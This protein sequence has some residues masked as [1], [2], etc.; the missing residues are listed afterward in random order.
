MLEAEAMEHEPVLNL[1]PHG[2]QGS[3]RRCGR[4][5]APQQEEGGGAMPAQADE[6]AAAAAAEGADAEDLVSMQTQVDELEAQLK[7]PELSQATKYGLKRQL[8]IAKAKLKKAQR[9]QPPQREAP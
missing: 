6:P 4:Q 2:T 8:A 1:P 5:Q 9:A 7:A 3:L